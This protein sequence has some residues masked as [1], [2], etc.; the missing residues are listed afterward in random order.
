MLDENGYGL[1]QNF[2]QTRSLRDTAALLDCLAVPQT[3]DPFAIPRPATRW[4][5][6]MQETPRPLRVGVSSAALMGVPVDPSAPRSGCPSR[7][8]LLTPSLHSL[9]GEGRCD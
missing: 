6:A 4:L 5:Q 3:G 1:A 7:V 8:T 9:M 2:A